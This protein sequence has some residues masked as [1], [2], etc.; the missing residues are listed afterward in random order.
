MALSPAYLKTR[1][2][3]PGG[4]DGRMPVPGGPVTRPMPFPEHGCRGLGAFAALPLSD[5]IPKHT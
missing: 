2:G 5:F 4:L 1:F 3:S